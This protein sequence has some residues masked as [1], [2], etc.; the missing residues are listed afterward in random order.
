M[1]T[2]GKI[3]RR[4]LVDQDSISEIVGDLGLSRNTVRKV[5]RSDGE[6][7]EYHRQRQPRPRLGPCL[8]LLTQWLDAVVTSSW[9]GRAPG[10]AGDAVV[11]N[12]GVFRSDNRDDI[13][14]LADEQSGLGYFAN[15]GKTRR[16][17][18]ELGASSRLG[19]VALGIRC[20]LLEATYRSSQTLVGA[21][22]S[23]SDAAPGFDSNITVNFG[24]PI[25]LRPRQIVKANVQ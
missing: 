4:R 25:P 18:V 23:S 19:P 3:R 15:F 6:R 16:Q 13:I 14:F 12:A 20:M 17:G 9:E 8:P 21:G 11:W 24:D 10:V 7:G 5:L 22:N 1:E 2:I